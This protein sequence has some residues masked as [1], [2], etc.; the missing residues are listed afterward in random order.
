MMKTNFTTLFLFEFIE[1]RLIQISTLSL[2][3]K[4][5]L[6]ASLPIHIKKN[7]IICTCIV[8][9]LLHKHTHT[10]IR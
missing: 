10:T 1:K 3:I 7:P 9:L 5:S 4:N 8:I 2:Y 6:H